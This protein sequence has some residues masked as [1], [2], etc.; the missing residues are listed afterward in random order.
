MKLRGNEY[1][2]ITQTVSGMHGEIDG[3]R[4]I[5][6]LKLTGTDGIIFTRS[7]V[8]NTADLP[9]NYDPALMENNPKEVTSIAFGM[10]LLSEEGYSTLGKSQRMTLCRLIESNEG[11]VDINLYKNG[12]NI[13]FKGGMMFI[14]TADRVII[15]SSLLELTRKFLTEKIFSKEAKAV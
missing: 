15:K 5:F 6:N 11:C 9:I 2:L 13:E 7:Y 12:T 14:G 3:E 4:L 8:F 10:F 1:T